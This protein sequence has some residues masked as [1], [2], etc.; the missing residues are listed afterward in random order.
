[1]WFFSVCI[2][3]MPRV[4]SCFI[5]DLTRR[6]HGHIVQPPRA[7]CVTVPVVAKPSTTRFSTLIDLVMISSRDSLLIAHDFLIFASIS[8]QNNQT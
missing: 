4:P 5:L 3:Q 6:N 2:L 1:M 8:A 7:G